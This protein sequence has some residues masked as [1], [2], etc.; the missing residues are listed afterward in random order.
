MHPVCLFCNTVKVPNVEKSIHSLLQKKISTRSLK[1]KFLLRLISNL[2]SCQILKVEVPL[3]TEWSSFISSFW[4]L[5]RFINNLSLWCRSILRG[6]SIAIFMFGYAIYF[7][8]KSNMRG[9]LQL[10]FFFGYNACICYALFLMLGTISFRASLLFVQHIYRSV[11][12]EW[13]H[14]CISRG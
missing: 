14:S 5:H 10:S 11:K 6:G 12:N 7:Y 9:F 4:P 2:I 13:S 8:A 1:K 3:L